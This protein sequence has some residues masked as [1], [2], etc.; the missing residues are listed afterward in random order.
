MSDLLLATEGGQVVAF[1]SA[2][3]EHHCVFKSS[4]DEAMMGIEQVGRDLYVA[5]LSR[6]YRLN[7]DDF[8][9][10]T[11]TQLYEP[12]PDFH[13]MQWYEDRLY[14]TSTKINEIWI[15]DKDLNLLETHLVTPPNPKR[16]AKY[17]KNY[18]HLNNIIKHEGRFYIDLNWLTT[19]QYA[20]SGV[21][22]TDKN[23]NEIERFEFGWETHD[24][25]FIDGKRVAICAT[26]GK[27]K[28]VKH[29]LRSGLMVEGELVFEHDSEESFCKGLCY[30]DEFIYLCGGRKMERKHRKNSNSIIYILDRRDY[31]LVRMF[32]SKEIKAIK[33]AILRKPIS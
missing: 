24:F 21:L 8:S 19:T 25:Q 27:G 17:K 31:S 6:I 26:S 7:L 13:Q 33:G 20:N 15:F 11:Q 22:V 9:K 23:L 1:N 3:D 16:R 14:M 28:R 30:D 32:E 4:D 12:T 10:I 5:S 29:V 18:N 2:T